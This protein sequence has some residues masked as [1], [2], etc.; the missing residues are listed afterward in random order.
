M[1]SLSL[2]ALSHPD[3]HVDSTRWY[4]YRLAFEGGEEFMRE[5][6]LRTAEETNDEFRDRKRNT[7]IPAV[8]KEAVKDV[9]R[10]ITQ[11]LADVTRS[12]GST[13]Y[14][15]AVAGEGSGVDREGQAMDMFIG[16]DLLEELLVMGRAGVFVDNVPPDGPTLADGPAKPYAY[17][18]RVEDILNWRTMRPEEEGTYSMILLRDREVT[19][20]QAFGLKFPNKMEERFRLVWIGEDGFMRYRFMDKQ[21]NQMTPEVLNPQLVIED[22]GAI[23]TQLREIPFVMPRLRTSLLTDVVGYQRLL[24]NIASN[25]GMFGINMNSPMLF[26]Q[27]DTRADGQNW[28]KPVGGAEEPGGQRSRTNTERQG[29]RSG[30]VRGRYY[31]LEENV[32]QWGNMPVESLEASS[33]YRQKLADEVRQLVNVAVQNQ[34]GT[35]TESRETREISAQ[36][37]ESGLFFI[38]MKLQDVERK[39]AKYFGIYEGEDSAT[40]TYPKR[41]NLKTQQERIKDAQEFKKVIDDLPTQEL[42]KE[43]IKRIVL[44]LFSGTV[45]SETMERMMRAIDRHPYIG[46]FDN[47]MALIEAGLITRELAGGSVDL[48]AEEVKKAAEEKAKMAAE[49]LE[50]QAKIKAENAPERPAARGVPEADA[51][52][53]SGKEE[54]AEDVQKR[55]AQKAPTQEE[56]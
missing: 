52:P 18:Y 13:H 39:I 4:E 27:R 50:T 47:V 7:P 48:D 29:I 55:G 43:G 3:F 36:G 8:A 56:K 9:Q 37:L 16:Q 26:I 49:I 1:A 10:A 19:F 38:A 2:S 45:S 6:L 30:W 42:K 51:N 40:V 21:L 24:M 17:V 31:G 34:T 41:F 46:G 14:Q 53:S 22:D 28:K 44:D 54:R 33:N 35:R 23:R 11:R 20:S 5:Y 12:G 32:P 25:E 15:A